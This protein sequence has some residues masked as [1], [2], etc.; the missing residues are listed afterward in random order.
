MKQSFTYD[1][2]LT[3]SPPH[4]NANE[5]SPSP[6]P[7]PQALVTEPPSTENTTPDAVEGLQE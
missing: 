4:N 7:C 1:D 2:P 3:N 6:T 5:P